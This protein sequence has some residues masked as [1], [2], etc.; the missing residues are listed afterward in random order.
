[1]SDRELLEAIALKDESA[2][3]AFYDRYANLLYKWCINRVGIVELTEEITQDF[4]MNIWLNPLKIKTD[5]TSSVDK[6]L[7]RHFSFHIM[8]YMKAV[9]VKAERE[10]QLPNVEEHPEQDKSYTHIEEDLGYEELNRVI[11]Q[12]LKE[13]PRDSREVFELIYKRGHTIKESAAILKLNDRTVGYKSK[14]SIQY[15]R[16]SLQKWYG[17]DK[18]VSMKVLKDTSSSIMYVMVIVDG[19][20]R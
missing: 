3:N 17:D 5:D 8:D 15:I 11:S 13:L 9:Y 19:L 16:K 12:I 4:W 20:L 1:M 10:G 2:F 7:L 6:F 14:E 18:A